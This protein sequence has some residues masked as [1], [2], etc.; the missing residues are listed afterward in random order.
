MKNTEPD[1]L[2]YRAEAGASRAETSSVG[3]PVLGMLALATSMA[4]SLGIIALLDVDFFATWTTFFVVACVPA[5]IVISMVWELDYPAFA[6]NLKQPFKG[7]FFT[8]LMLLVAAVVATAIYLAQP[9]PAGPPTPFVLMYAIF[10]VLVAFWL[11]IVWGCW[12]LSALAGHPL[13]LGLGILAVAYGGGF[14]LFRLLF[15]FA[16]LGGAPFYSAAMDPGGAFPAFHA[17]AFSVTTVSLLFF[18]VLFDFWPISAF[19]ALRVQPAQGLAATVYILGLSALAYWLGIGLLEMEPVPFMVHVSIGC[20]FGALVPLILFEGKL[21]A[22]L[23]QP[24]KGLGQCTVAVIAA[25]LLPA[26]YRA[27]AP[28]VSGPLVSGAPGYQYEFWM[29]SALLAMT[30]PVMVVVGKFLD[31]WPWRR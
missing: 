27:V 18:C 14:G 5:Q 30:F 20:L 31:F 26:L 21:F 28:L 2:E 6:R 1:S 19:P 22:G 16:A 3:Q 17:L 13:A 10:C 4:V 12:P 7:L 23:R 25:V 15:D 11:V 9:V 29:A 24:L 8:A